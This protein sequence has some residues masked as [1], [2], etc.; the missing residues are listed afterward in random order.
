VG[1]TLDDV[2]AHAG[3]GAIALV[4]AAGRLGSRPRT[5]MTPAPMTSTGTGA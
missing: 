3:V 1:A 4:P 5:T 2:A